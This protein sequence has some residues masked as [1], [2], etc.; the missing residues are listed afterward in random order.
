MDS[1]CPVGLSGIRG[2]GEVKLALALLLASM[3][4]GLVGCISFNTFNIYDNRATS[5]PE[6]K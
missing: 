4:G 3:L 1:D 2:G 6:K 5:Q